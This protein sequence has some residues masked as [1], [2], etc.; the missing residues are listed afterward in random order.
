MPTSATAYSRSWRVVVALLVAL[1]RGSLLAMA[2]ALAF[3]ET[4]LEN[5]LRL[6]R[7]FVVASAAPGL[8]A[9]LLARAFAASVS[10]ADGLLVI[11]RRD[12]RIEIPCAA[13]VAVEAWRTPLPAPGVAFRLRSGARAAYGLALAPPS[14]LGVLLDVIAA[15]GG[16]D[17]VR[18]AA[19]TPAAAYA[20]SR[21]DGTGR[22]YRPLLQYVAF[23]LVP[24]LPLFRLHQWVAYGGTFGEYYTYGLR[25]YLL[26]FAAYWWTLAIYL[27]LWSAV[28]RALVEAVV[29]ATAWI[30][31]PATARVRRLAER[32]YWVAFVG[33]VPLFLVRV[34]LLAS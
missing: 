29:L 4:P 18:T 33:G 3:T 19:C 34:A 15:G 21:V 24:T 2:F 7:T 20:T 6:L 31:P 1:G 32:A 23:A 25:A 27:V 22:W 5:P 30:V 14:A 12:R 11:A 13:I 10:V 28:L 26:G 16:G 9:W 8:A 17:G